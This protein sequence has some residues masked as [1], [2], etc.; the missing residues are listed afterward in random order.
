MLKKDNQDQENQDQENQDQENQDQTLLMQKFHPPRRYWLVVFL[1]ASDPW[2]RRQLDGY[3]FLS[4]HIKTTM[5]NPKNNSEYIQNK[6]QPH[7]QKDRA[8]H[9]T[10]PCQ[11][12]VFSRET[13][14]T[15]IFQF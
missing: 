7:L 8:P 10:Q 11:T 2:P 3:L 13:Q 4:N 1:V 6:K 5:I 12:S 15:S 14:E 9:W